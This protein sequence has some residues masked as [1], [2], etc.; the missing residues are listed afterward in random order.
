M[1]ISHGLRHLV[2]LS[3]AFALL[4]NGLAWSQQPGTAAAA[5][6]QGQLRWTP[7]RAA[8]AS[9]TAATDPAPAGVTAATKPAAVL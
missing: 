2:G 5:G 4:G 9:E 7:H 1:H 6:G 8:T 3:L